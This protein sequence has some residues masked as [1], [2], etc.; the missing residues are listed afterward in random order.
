M[1]FQKTL[2]MYQVEARLEDYAQKTVF[3]EMAEMDW[4]M[5]PRW[6]GK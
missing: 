4:K 6:I 3:E 2:A 1:N 5:A